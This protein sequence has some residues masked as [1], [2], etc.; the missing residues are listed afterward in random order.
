LIL[1]K[2]VEKMGRYDPEYILLKTWQEVMSREY[3]MYSVPSV[4]GDSFLDTVFKDFDL[5]WKNPRFSFDDSFPPINLYV[6]QDDKA[7]TYELALTGYKKDWLSVE[8]DGNNL[9][10]SA[11]VPEEKEDSKQYIKRRIKAKSF[12]KTYKIPEGYDTEKAEVSYEDGLLTLF[13]PVKTK[14]AETTKKLLIK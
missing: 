7:C 2:I 5:M 6:N 13:V 1:I 8:L 4:F 3:R 14:P 11:N 9:K 12:E 10:I